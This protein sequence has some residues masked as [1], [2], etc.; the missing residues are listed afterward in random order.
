MAMIQYGASDTRIGVDVVSIDRMRKV[1]LRT[2]GIVDKVLTPDEREYA[3]QKPNPV[4]HVAARFAAKEAVRKALGH[5]V[6]WRHIEVRND[7][8]GAPALAFDE[9]GS[10]YG[11]VAITASSVSISHDGDVAMACVLISTAH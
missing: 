3:L 4:H 9:S 11:G 6:E 10:G 2:P 7:E 1:M 8:S 5:A